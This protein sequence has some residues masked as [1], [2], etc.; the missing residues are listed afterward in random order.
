MKSSLYIILSLILILLYSSCSTTTDITGESGG[1]TETIGLVVSSEGIPIEGVNIEFIP[2]D[3]IPQQKSGQFIHRTSNESG[4]FSFI[5][6][7]D[8]AYN[9]MYTKGGELAFRESLSVV[10]GKLGSTIVDTLLPFGSVYGVVQLH[11]NHNSGNV[12]I[13]LRGTNR[14][15]TPLDSTG[16]FTVDSL[17]EGEY[18]I[19]FIADYDYYAQYDTTII[20]TSSLM[21]TLKDTIT[22]EYLGIETPIISSMEYD[23]ALL[24][25]TVRWNAVESSSLAGYQVFRKAAHRDSTPISI[26]YLVQ[27]TFF[28]DSCNNTTVLEGCKYSYQVSCINNEQMS[29]KLSDETSITYSSLFPKSDSL[30]IVQTAKAENVSMVCTDSGMLYLV[31]SN[32]ALLH[33]IDINNM[34]Y[35][36]SYPLPDSAI[37]TAISLMEDNSLLIATHKGVYNI[38]TTGVR[39]WRYSAFHTKSANGTSGQYTRSI[40]SLDLQY[41]Y[42][43]SSRKNY[44]SASVVQR[45]NCYSG[46]SDTLGILQDGE[47]TSLHI[48]PESNMLYLAIK[49]H[50]RTSLESTSLSQFSLLTIYDCKNSNDVHFSLNRDSSFSFL[51]SGTL[52]TI[53]ERELT[54]KDKKFLQDNCQTVASLHTG[55]RIVINRDGYIIKIGKNK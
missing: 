9:L 17:A 31:S 12:F 42:Y 23:P 41:F 37:P 48:E 26:A 43:T 34:N 19:T 33:K 50:N 8:G 52:L 4:E 36:A 5:G 7:P 3:Y 13:L 20:I 32:E 15:C 44:N 46:E 38:D 24:H 11:E 29:G 14:F 54:I 39:L 27:D 45:F 1:V 30:L 22:L 25:G 16:Q 40:S 47:I 2:T 55:E 18:R 6:I 21:D 51:N 49:Y 10:N 28:V 35:L 53:E